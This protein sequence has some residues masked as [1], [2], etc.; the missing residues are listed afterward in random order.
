MVTVVLMVVASFV[1]VGVV[2]VLVVMVVLE[3]LVVV[4]YTSP[5]VDRGDGDI[6]QGEHRLHQPLHHLFHPTPELL[7]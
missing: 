1:E 7:M 2:L 6:Q 3:M 4:V 5:R